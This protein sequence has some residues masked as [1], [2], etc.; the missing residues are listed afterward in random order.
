[1]H[2][3]HREEAGLDENG[4]YH[5]A[6]EQFARWAKY[7]NHQRPH[8]ALRYLCPIDYYHGDPEARLT[9][10]RGKLAAAQA[11]RQAYWRTAQP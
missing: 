5:A 4:G 9:G 11:A 7:Y 3:T 2:R 1:M 6:L 10:R 8:W